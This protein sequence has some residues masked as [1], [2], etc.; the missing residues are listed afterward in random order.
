MCFGTRTES[1]GE[2]IRIWRVHHPVIATD[3]TNIMVV[4][5]RTADRGQGHQDQ[6]HTEAHEDPDPRITVVHGRLDLTED[7]TQGQ[8]RDHHPKEKREA[9]RAG[10]EQGHVPDLDPGQG[11]LLEGKIELGRTDIDPEQDH[12]PDLQAVVAVQGETPDT[13]QCLN[14]TG[15][16]EKGGKSQKV[17]ETW[18]LGN[19]M[20]T[21]LLEAKG[22]GPGQLAY[23]HCSHC[24]YLKQPEVLCIAI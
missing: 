13:V 24:I 11:H 20:V 10:P 21:N 8:D 18:T 7:H 3:V 17:M 15:I 4:R 5:G 14:E 19:K 23:G 6:G 1:S 2:P 22:H 16:P 9:R 12:V